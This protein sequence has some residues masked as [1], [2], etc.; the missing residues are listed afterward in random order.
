MNF[1]YNMV[2]F[3]SQA[4]K[5]AQKRISSETMIDFVTVWQGAG[6]H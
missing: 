2:N 5:N 6:C 1:Y 3:V 4:I